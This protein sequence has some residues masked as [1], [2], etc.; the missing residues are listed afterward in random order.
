MSGGTV[1]FLY[2][3]DR[4]S[5]CGKTIPLVGMSFFMHPATN[6]FTNFALV[7]P[8]IFVE[9]DRGMV[10]VKAKSRKAF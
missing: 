7:C 1:H 9:D 8:Q 3:Q 5:L 6:I 2:Q 4:K 10:P